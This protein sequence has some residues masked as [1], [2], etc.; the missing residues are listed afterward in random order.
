[1]TIDWNDLISGYND[2]FNCKLTLK[3]M[4]QDC[5]DRSAKCDFK[6]GH[7]AADILGVSSHCFYER[8]I[9]F[10]I[11]LHNPGGRTGMT[12]IEKIRA[13][14]DG[15]II[16]MSD[17]EIAKQI[18]CVPEH[19]SYIR[20]HYPNENKIKLNICPHCGRKGGKRINGCYLFLKW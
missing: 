2:R 20:K 16:F 18:G 3:E 1:M 8:L 5:Y 6:S 9:E 7:R 15:D 10:K 17:T 11:K 4:I 13:I 14:P 12:A 19:I